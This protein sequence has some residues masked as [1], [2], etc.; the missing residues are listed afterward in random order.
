MR[1]SVFKNL[2]FHTLRATDTLHFYCLLSI[3][4]MCTSRFSTHKR[5]HYLKMCGCSTFY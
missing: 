4:H 5:C 1:V 2:I 3:C